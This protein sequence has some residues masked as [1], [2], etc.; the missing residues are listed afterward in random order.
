MRGGTSLRPERRYQAASA[1]GQRE[2]V[3]RKHRYQ[4]LGYCH[5]SSSLVGGGDVA[6]GGGDFDAIQGGREPGHRDAEEDAPECKNEQELRK[7]EGLSHR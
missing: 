1:N 6:C 4:A 7:G 2:G 5:Q 3:N